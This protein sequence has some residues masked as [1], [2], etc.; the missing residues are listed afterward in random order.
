MAKIGE[1]YK[2]M[3][4]PCINKCPM[5][6]RI[7]FNIRSQFSYGWGIDSAIRMNTLTELYLFTKYRTTLQCLALPNIETVMVNG[8]IKKITSKKLKNLVCT[9]I[10]ENMFIN[11]DV[12]ELDV[13]INGFGIYYKNFPR[14]LLNKLDEWNINSNKYIREM[15]GYINKPSYRHVWENGIT[16]TE[17]MRNVIHSYSYRDSHII[18]RGVKK[19]SKIVVDEGIKWGFE[20]IVFNP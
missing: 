18:Y 8:Y 14:G 20:E 5:I 4:Q 13:F 15:C 11:L 6:R 9:I 16:P 17:F 2:N 7:T 10:Y 19:L 3:F 1:S 12:Y